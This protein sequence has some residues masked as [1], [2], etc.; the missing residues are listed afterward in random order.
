LLPSGS[1][2]S[3][4]YVWLIAIAFSQVLINQKLSKYARIALIGLLLITFYVTFYK[5]FGWK[6][7]WIPPLAALGTIIILRYPKLGIILAVLAVII[8]RDAPSQ[9]ISTDE[10]SYT[11]RLVAWEIIWKEIIKVN[12]FLG[13]GPA[14]YY[15]Y[16]PLYPILGF[17]VE[18]NSHNNYVDLIAQIGLLG[19]ASFAWFAVELGILGGK[20]LKKIPNGFSQAYVYA[21]LG[22]LVGTLVAGMLGDWIIPFVY[23]IGLRGF[24]ASVIGWLFMGGLVVIEQVYSAQKR[25]VI[26]ES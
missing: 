3:L 12:P 24:R 7:G 19:L 14:N 15:Y 17:S 20:L 25:E 16:T 2:G 18:F 5:Q 22:G 1:R 26:S 4:F 10:Y 6:S 8:F 11:T 21:V 13:L 9:I 23:N